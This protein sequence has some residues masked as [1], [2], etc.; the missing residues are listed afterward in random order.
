MTPNVSSLINA[1]ADLLLG[2]TCPGCDEPGWGLCSSCLAAL[3][4]DPLSLPGSPAGVAA[5]G[6]RPILVRVIPR[7][8]DDGA[9]HLEAA[10]GR[11]LARA[12]LALEPPSGAVLVPV[13]SLKSAVRARGYDHARR[14]TAVAA[15]AT[16]LRAAA[17]LSRDSHSG[18]QRGLSKAGRR[19]NLV[20]TMTARAHTGPVILVDDVRTTGASLAEGNRALR[21]ARIPIL[22]NAV[23]ALADDAPD[24]VAKG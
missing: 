2:A 7:F 8:K 6:Y 24:N 14:L 17:L 15:K 4:T 1:A 12:V 5:A 21:A 18:H 11:L 16:G 3:Q 20:G 22:G 10:L 23:V 13:P 19:A 9:L